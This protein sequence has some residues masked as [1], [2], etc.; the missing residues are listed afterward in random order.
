V[1]FNEFETAK[2]LRRNFNRNLTESRTIFKNVDKGHFGE[3]LFWQ[4]TKARYFLQTHIMQ[5]QR[6]QQSPTFEKSF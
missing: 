1:K 2:I 6:V 5:T 4:A 3:E